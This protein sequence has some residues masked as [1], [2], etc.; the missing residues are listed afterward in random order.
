[1]LNICSC[2]SGLVTFLLLLLLL[3]PRT[4]LLLLWP[5]FLLFLLFLLLILLL[6]LLGCSM[7]WLDVGSQFP[8]QGRTWATAVKVLTN[9]P[10][11]SPPHLL[12]GT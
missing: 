9:R 5:V 2:A 3:L 4:L 6:L 10:P 7:Q 11:G 12:F 1:M 8:D